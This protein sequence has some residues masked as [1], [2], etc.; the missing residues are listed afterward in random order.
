[1]VYVVSIK[2]YFFPLQTENHLEEIS[3]FSPHRKKKRVYV[4]LF[5]FRFSILFIPKLTCNLVYGE[6]MILFLKLL[7]HF[8]YVRPKTVS[9]ECDLC[10]LII[11]LVLL[12][13]DR[14]VTSPLFCCSSAPP[15]SACKAKS[16][17]FVIYCGKL[18]FLFEYHF[19]FIPSVELLNGGISFI[20][21]QFQ[22]ISRQTDAIE[23]AVTIYVRAVPCRIKWS[24]CATATA[25]VNNWMQFEVAHVA[26][27]NLNWNCEW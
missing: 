17:W 4:L 25:N 7:P 20:Q 2:F 16:S 26:L 22:L 8:S 9:Y 18:N 24:E 14:T 21:L 6:I 12:Q 13:S 3:F 15:P 19:S 5:F 11:N 1:M 23:S 10:N 27:V